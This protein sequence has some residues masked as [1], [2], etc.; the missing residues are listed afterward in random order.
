MVNDG[1]TSKIL[2]DYSTDTNATWTESKSGNYTITAFVKDTNG[3][4]VSKS[5]TYVISDTIAKNETTIYYKGYTSP[6]IHY[7]VGNGSWTAAPGVSMIPTA[8]MP[9]YT[10]KITIDLGIATTLTACFNNGSGIWD[11]RNGANYIFGVGKYTDGNGTSITF[12]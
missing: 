6:Y 1:V 3:K 9:G 11:S 7:R 8:E 12:N 10:H 2:K 4:E 5:M